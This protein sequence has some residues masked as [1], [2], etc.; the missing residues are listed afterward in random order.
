ME[1]IN[2]ILETKKQKEKMNITDLI[3]VI[4]I[5]RQYSPQITSRFTA[6]SKEV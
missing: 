6:K 4:M 3:C 1:Y 2:N 5:L